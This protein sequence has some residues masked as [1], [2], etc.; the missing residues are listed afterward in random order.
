MT[1]GARCV[2]DIT[3]SIIY[4]VRYAYYY[5]DYAHDFRKNFLTF[6]HFFDFVCIGRQMIA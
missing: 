4:K 6:I 5:V 2:K 1:A 3:F